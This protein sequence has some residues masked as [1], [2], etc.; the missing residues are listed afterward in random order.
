[1]K[2]SEI[3]ITI[4]NYSQDQ[5]K[6]VIS[7]MYKAI[8]KAI[9]EEKDID[10]IVKNPDI[11]RSKGRD[12]AEDLPDIQELQSDAESF[13]EDARNQYYFIPNRI[14]S[15][16]DR[17]KWR[18][19]V[20]RLYKDLLLTA[21]QQEN[22][23]QAAQLLEK[24]YELLC[25]SCK[26]VLF[27]AYDSFRSVGIEQAEFFRKVLTLKAQS[28]DQKIFIK[29][30]LLLLINNSLNR[31]TVHETLIKVILEFLKTPDS[32]EQS[33]V[34]C[35]ELFKTVKD[36]PSV[37]KYDWSVTDYAKIEKLNNLAEMGFFC[38]AQLFEYE[39]A[40]DY[41]KHHYQV[42]DSEVLLYI[43]LE[44]LFELNQKQYFV[45]EYEKALANGVIPRDSLVNVYRFIKEK[46][47]MPAMFS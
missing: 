32:R 29:N 39:K 12:K 30:A 35:N 2:V 8:P 10:S 6:C 3:K 44:L 28:E 7:Q 42:K 22:I 1:L 11:I 18:F 27:S 37:K 41:F 23:P 5:L 24:L 33:I 16:Q 9:R 43:L 4:D 15:K 13:M 34:V 20:K 19:I 31:Y 38:Y 21:G 46:G 36:E 14:I 47:E 17:P 26:E 45:E 25:L 40:I